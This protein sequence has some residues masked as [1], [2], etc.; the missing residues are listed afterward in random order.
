MEMSEVFWMS[1]ITII[2][3]MTMALFG[4]CYKSKCK[5]IQLGCIKIDRDVELE[6]KELE[7]VQTH[8]QQNVI[9]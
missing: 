7:F 2:S 8:Q 1:F 5:T 9:V 6:E 4:I 3:G